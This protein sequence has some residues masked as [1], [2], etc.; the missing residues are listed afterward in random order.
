M[1]S[2]FA[3]LTLPHSPLSIDF[4]TYAWGGVWPGYALE[5]EGTGELLFFFSHSSRSV[6]VHI[7]FVAMGSRLSALSLAFQ[8]TTHLPGAHRSLSD[9]W[10][11]NHVLPGDFFLL[12][13]LPV[14]PA[15]EDLA[16]ARFSR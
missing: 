13:S 2:L 16:A 8:Q 5:G 11:D 12:C 4:R 6:A 15:T 7:G 9:I 3:R 10:T 14:A 1:P